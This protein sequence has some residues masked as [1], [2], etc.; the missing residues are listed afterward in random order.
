ME[1]TP[2]QGRL[3]TSDRLSLLSSMIDSVQKELTK[4]LLCYWHCD[5]PR[6]Y[7]NDAGNN[8]FCR[9]DN[10]GK[11]DKKYGYTQIKHSTII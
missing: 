2:I 4:A 1:V 11:K 5:H 9:V 6:K 7:S 10:L 3:M 8:A